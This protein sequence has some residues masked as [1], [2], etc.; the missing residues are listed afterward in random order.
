[1]SVILV[2]I[3]CTGP[4]ITSTRPPAYLADCVDQYLTFNDD[5]LF[6]L[7][8]EENLQYLPARE[9]VESFAIEGY[10]S[11]KITQFESLYNFGPREFWTIATTRL[12]Y[13]ENFMRDHDVHHV[14]EFANDVLVYFDVEKCT[15]VFERLYEH[16][17]LTPCGPRNIQDGFMYV[18][19]HRALA[20][21]TD[22]FVGVIDDLGLEGVKKRYDLDMINEM[23]LMKCYTD[24]HPDR[25]GRLPILPWG[26]HST[27]YD[28]FNAIFDPASWGQF[29]G[30]T[31]T[32]GPGAKFSVHHIGQVLIDHPQYGVDWITEDGLRV[33]YFNHDGTLTKLNS[34]HIHSKNLREFVS[35]GGSQ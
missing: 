7:T 6:I 21:M 20:H 29:V 11:D 26:E 32:E 28:E 15:P 8:D 31:R 23:T 33:P 3:G 5:T 17:A 16:L 30:G 34:L 19:D 10:H 12:M 18:H 14:C 13:I 25:V 1:M 4:Y 27:H 9:G 22:F 35:R 2:H 24:E